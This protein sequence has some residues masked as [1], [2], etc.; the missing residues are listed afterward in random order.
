MCCVHVFYMC[1]ISLSLRHRSW[2]TV[3]I[4]NFRSWLYYYYLIIIISQLVNSFNPNP[5]KQLIRLESSWIN[6]T[7]KSSSGRVLVP[8]AE[9]VGLWVATCLLCTQPKWCPLKAPLSQ[10]LVCSIDLSCFPFRQETRARSLSLS[11][12]HSRD[13]FHRNDGHSLTFFSHIRPVRSFTSKCKSIHTR[14][15]THTTHSYTRTHGRA[16]EQCVSATQARE[17][18][19]DSRALQALPWLHTA[20]LTLNGTYTNAFLQNK[21][22]KTNTESFSRDKRR[23]PS[24]KDKTNC[25]VSACSCFGDT[26]RTN[27][28]ENDYNMTV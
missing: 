27:K 19:R 3:Q 21:A 25:L 16:P 14:A 10:S 4:T 15:R 6:F 5:F 1:T 11:R 28:T 9:T 23:S 17:R 13:Q 18:A 8:N 2:H 20:H 22:Q 7:V 24:Y 12:T 26:S